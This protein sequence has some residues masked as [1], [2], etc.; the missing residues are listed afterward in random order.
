ME[1]YKNNKF[2]ITPE[3]ALIDGLSLIS[4]KLYGFIDGKRTNIQPVSELLLRLAIPREKT[5]VNSEDIFIAVEQITSLLESME[6]RRKSG[7]N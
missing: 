3:D 1:N 4:Q 7:L 6:E 5:S 2:E